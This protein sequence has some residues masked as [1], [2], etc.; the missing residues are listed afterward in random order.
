MCQLE[1]ARPNGVRLMH[2]QRPPVA[3]P[4]EARTEVLGV[5]EEV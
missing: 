5:V 3:I 4:R 2:C 1:S